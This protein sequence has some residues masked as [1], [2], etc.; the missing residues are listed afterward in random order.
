MLGNDTDPD[1]DPLTA[2]LGTGPTNGTLALNADGSFSYTPN[3]ES[4]G[5]DSFT[6]T[7]SDGQGGTDTA[8][9]TIT[10]AS[11]NDPPVATDDAYPTDEDTPLTV[12][13]TGCVGK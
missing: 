9:V 7:A 4:S 11:V 6:Y 12:A 2:I 3:A 5:T 10:V 1:G 8:T 13:C